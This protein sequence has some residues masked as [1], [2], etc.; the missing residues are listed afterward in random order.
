MKEKFAPP[1]APL[2][3]YYTITRRMVMPLAESIL[4]ILAGKV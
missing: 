2:T 3:E 1:N 4:L